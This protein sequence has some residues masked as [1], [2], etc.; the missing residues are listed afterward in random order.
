MLK[1]SLFDNETSPRR[2]QLDPISDSIE[3][4]KGHSKT[5]K[6]TR[7]NKYAVNEETERNDSNEV[8]SDGRP[9]KKRKKKKKANKTVPVHPGEMNANQNE[10]VLPAPAWRTPR[11]PVKSLPPVKLQKNENAFEYPSFGVH[12]SQGN[13]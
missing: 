3:L 7:N 4:D 13:V 5:H 11:E 10:S 1:S 9:K 6:K 12:E 8:D 2:R